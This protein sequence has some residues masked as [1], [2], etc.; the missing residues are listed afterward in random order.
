MALDLH[1]E[2]S[3]DQ[4]WLGRTVMLRRTWWT[5][6]TLESLL[7]SITSRSSV[8]LNQGSVVPLPQIPSHNEEERQITANFNIYAKIGVIAHDAL[9]TLYPVRVRPLT[10]QNI[11][12]YFA[13][14]KSDLETLLPEIND[15]KHSMLHFAWFDAMILITRPGLFLSTND[16]VP[17]ET[18]PDMQEVARTCIKA[19]H[20]MTR[21]LSNEPS[22][23]I[24]QNGPWWCLVHYIMRAMTVFLLVMSRQTQWPG[25]LYL[26]IVISA[27]KLIHWL[28]WMRPNDRVADCA[29]QIV[30]NTVK[31]A[32]YHADFAEFLEGKT[33]GSLEGFTFGNDEWMGDFDSDY[34]FNPIGGLDHSLDPV[35]ERTDE[36]Q[37]PL[38]SGELSPAP[39]EPLGVTNN[40]WVW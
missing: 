20:A 9:L 18:V 24:F 5:V 19:A 16:S 21:L 38:H 22:A 26:E 3:T 39:G 27:K 34:T 30:L 4:Q 12:S 8:L 28:Q 31:H 13:K 37:S 15:R 14:P 25:Q 2:Q 40:P 11:E 32:S 36:M 1:L 23:N 35:A 33:L 7:S 17:E 29:L 10:Q 6:R